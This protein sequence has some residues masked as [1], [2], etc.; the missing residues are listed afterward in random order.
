LRE[1]KSLKKL[2][3]L[4]DYSKFSQTAETDDINLSCCGLKSNKEDVPVAPT[5]KKENTMKFNA[6]KLCEGL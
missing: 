5:E 3:P 1:W 6:K 4:K 2:S